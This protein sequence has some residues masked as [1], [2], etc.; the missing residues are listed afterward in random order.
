MDANKAVPIRGLLT[1]EAVFSLVS[2][3]CAQQCGREHSGLFCCAATALSEMLGVGQVVQKG[4][5]QGRSMWILLKGFLQFC[6]VHLFP[7]LIGIRF[8][9][10]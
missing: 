5:W 7:T 6:A 9:F 1:D 2:R 4:F 3:L 10:P 8:S